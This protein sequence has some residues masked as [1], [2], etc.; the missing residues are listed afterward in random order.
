MV[1]TAAS[2]QNS[3]RAS[4]TWWF[5]STLA[6][7]LLPAF[8]LAQSSE[9]EESPDP[10]FYEGRI[11]T[12]EEAKEATVPKGSKPWWVIGWPC[13]TIY[14]GMEK[15][16]IK[17]EKGKFRAKLY[18]WQRRLAAAGFRPLSEAAI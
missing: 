4:K 8:V 1:F 15:G 5:A 3:D 18:D 16:L 6:I 2:G 10:S 9:D 14:G 12:P 7:V 17:F 11:V 13:R